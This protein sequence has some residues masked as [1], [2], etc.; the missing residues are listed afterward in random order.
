M[1]GRRC[2]TRSDE[3]AMLIV[4]LII[5]TVVALVTG[6]LLTL[7]QGNFLA[8]VSLRKVAANAYASDAAAKLAI[9]DLV[10]GQKA[11]ALASGAT[12]PSGTPNGWVYDNN[13]D[14]SGC[15]GIAGDGSPLS[16]ITMPSVY[17]DSQSGSSMSAT[18]VCQPVTGTGLFG[19]GTYIVQPTSSD[20]FAKALTTVGTAPGANGAV[21]GISFKGLGSGSTIPI[22]GSIASRSTITVDAGALQTNGTIAANTSCTAKNSGS[23][24]PACTI[25]GVTAPT[26]PASPL[27]AVPAWKDPS[28]EGC[29]FVPGFYSSGATLSAAVNACSTAYFASGVYYFDFTDGVPWTI[30]TNVIGGVAVPGKPIPGA[31]KSPIDYPT[32]AGVQF[33]FGGS[34]SMFLTNAGSSSGQVELC[35]PGN[36]GQAP[37][38]I[39][40]QQS[41]STPAPTTVGP[42]AAATVANP[43]PLGTAMDSFTASSGTLPNAVAAVGG[44]TANLK[45]TK[46]GNGA[47]LDLQNFSGLS[48]IPSGSTITSAKLRVT[49]TNGLSTG[50]TFTAAVGGQATTATVAASG[51]DTDLTSQLNAQFVASGFNATSPKI[52]LLVA[53]TKKNDTLNIDAV[54]LTV[55]YTAPALRAASVGTFISSKTNFAGSFVVEGA[56]YA[57]Q[58]YINLQPGNATGSLIALRWGLVAYGAFFQSQPQQTFGYPLVSLPDIGYGLGSNVAAVDMTVYLCTGSGPCST[59]GSPA[60]TTRVQFTDYVCTAVSASP[61]CLIVGEVSPIPGQRQVQILSW[62]EQK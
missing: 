28:T 27:A 50:A 18:V 37:L 4:A 60:L 21:D 39:Y 30:T 48:A 32:T 55:A 62:A 25:G 3:G 20:P 2:F 42:S 11:G 16:Q 13:T 17:T 46:T 23:F 44:A 61:N 38:T 36:A 41:G 47:E 12:Y 52:Q 57:P 8:T 15:F 6:A 5:I 45:S 19:S 34:S 22:R 40:Q 51:T 56:T 59:T 31:C 33:V 49:Y 29:N 24:S 35:G 54:S 26:A 58:G 7:G 9:N 10:L 53:N 14:K 1:T 43:S